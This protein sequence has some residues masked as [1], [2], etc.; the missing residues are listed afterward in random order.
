MYSLSLWLRPE[1]HVSRIDSPEL[2]E[3][4]QIHV[5]NQHGAFPVFKVRLCATKES[6]GIHGNILA[7]RLQALKSNAD[8]DP[9]Q[10]HIIHSASCFLW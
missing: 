1:A 3:F 8:R 6:A 7:K 4:A 10:R 5:G 9:A 2:A